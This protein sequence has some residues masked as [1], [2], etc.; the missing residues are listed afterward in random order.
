MHQSHSLKN[1]GVVLL[2]LAFHF[3][4]QQKMFS[5]LY[6]VAMARVG[7]PCAADSKDSNKCLA[8]QVFTH[9]SL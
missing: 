8:F 9:F 1:I 2:L 4:I 5:L 7:S 6:E 3:Y